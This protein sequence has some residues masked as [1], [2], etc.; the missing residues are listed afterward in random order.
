VIRLIGWAAETDTLTD[1]RPYRL[2]LCWQV[3]DTP[4]RPAAY[5]VKVVRN[6]VPVGERTTLHGTGRYSSRAWGVGD[7]WCETLAVPITGTQPDTA[8]DVLLVL[9]DSETGAVDW[10]A[11]TSDGTPVPF[12]VLGQV[13]AR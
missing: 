11:T 9:L 7:T 12:P 4:T 13:T 1:N 8:Y 5:S 6:G 3:L 10:Q 2:T